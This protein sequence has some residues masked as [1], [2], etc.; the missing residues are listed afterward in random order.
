MHTPVEA[1]QHTHHYLGDRHDRHER[2]TWIV[3]GLTAIMMVAEIVGGTIYGSMAL[4][5]DGWHMSTHAGAIALA[6]LAYQFARRHVDDARFSF[7]TGKFGELAGF[8]SAVI[9]GVI[10]LM[11]GYESMLRLLAP[12]AISFEQAIM[13]AVLG[14]AVNLATARLLYDDDHHH[15]HD[16]HGLGERHHSDARDHNLRAAYFHVLADA[17]TSILAIVALLAGRLYGWVFLDPLMGVVGA[18]VIAIWSLGLMRS[19]GA[20]LL[21]MVPDRRL[22]ADIRRR[23]ETGEDRVVDLHLWR[24]GPGHLGLVA[25]VLSDRPSSAEACKARLEHIAGLSHQTI[26]VHSCRREA[27]DAAD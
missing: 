3:V 8:T 20:V 16:D 22:M 19:A 13:I 5:A 21:D 11:I 17:L 25:T 4:V 10:A 14:L 6:A 1:W 23:L 7:G 2:R 27:R 15:G 18:V 24:L 26:E 12:V 9:L